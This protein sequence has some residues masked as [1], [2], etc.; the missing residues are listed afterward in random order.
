MIVVG[1]VGGTRMRFALAER[2]GSDWRF[3]C[4]EQQDTVPQVAAALS[5]YLEAAGRPA[6]MGAAFCGAGPVLADGP[7]RPCEARRVEA[8]DWL[9]PRDPPIRH[10]ERI[11]TAWLEI[12]LTEGRNRQVRRMTAAVGLPTLRLV[13]LRIGDWT[14]GGLAP[15][16]WRRLGKDEA[17]R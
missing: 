15:G 10:R 11:P 13:R 7:T 9:W 3:A 5:R 2:S 1:D 14:L 6:L 17:L 4:L 12:V 16:Q 8:P